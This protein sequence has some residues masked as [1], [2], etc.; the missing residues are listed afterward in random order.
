MSVLFDSLAEAGFNRVL[1]KHWHRA[2]ADARA[3]AQLLPWF[4]DSRSSDDLTRGPVCA[5]SGVR[6][7]DVHSAARHSPPPAS[8]STAG[9]WW[10]PHDANKSPATDADRHRV[11]RRPQLS[12]SRSPP[13]Q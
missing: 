2:L 10:L 3:V 8:R 6:Q 11:R 7:H 12:R 5:R 1:K 13:R 4:C 9:R